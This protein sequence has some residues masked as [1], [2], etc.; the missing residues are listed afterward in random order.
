MSTLAP[1][2]VDLCD[3]QGN[4]LLPYSMKYANHLFVHFDEARGA[5]EWLASLVDGVT[6]ADPDPWRDGQKPGFTLNVAFTAAGLRALG[7][8]DGTMGTFSPEF[9]NGMLASARAL[10]D[11]G[12]SDPA[13][14][15]RGWEPGRVHAMVDV[16]SPSREGVLRQ[17]A[18]VA[19]AMR[20]RGVSDLFSQP[21]A[22]LDDNKEHFGFKDGFG[23]PWLDFAGVPGRRT[24]DHH[25]G[26]G[27]PD[28]KGGWRPVA[29]G[30]F[31]LGHDDEEGIL[32]EAP[33]PQALA[34][35]GTHLVY[36][37]LRQDVEA[38][39][40]YIDSQAQLLGVHAERVAAAMVGRWPDG[41]PLRLSPGKPD[42]DLGKNEDRNNDFT[43][44][45][46]PRGFAC[47]IGA[48]IRRANPR[49]SL[50]FKDRRR[51]ALLVSRHRMIRRGIPYGEPFPKGS[52]DR[53]L[54]FMAAMASLKR[55]FEFVQGQWLN[56]G[57]IFHL[58]ADRDP[59]A[60]DQQCNGKMTIQGC[61][62]KF[63]SGIPPLVVTRGGEYFFKP[64]I[65]AL[66]WLAG[67]GW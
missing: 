60:G 33:Y 32:P 41:S 21:A 35:N 22:R 8:P 2:Q 30:E 65:A 57:N 40:H 9:R 7:V 6:T 47:P 24:P 16:H 38:F 62:P 51:H 56:D 19:S 48:H 13:K 66:R 45:E 34:R 53:G 49:D 14:W 42:P 59:F 29:L 61:P 18:Q 4:I 15:D 50:G 46:D 26:Q 23:Q 39:R 43:Y 10:G 20:G 11:R 67:G 1:P 52:S 12:P 58:G 64:G 31:L 55:Q 3:I 5:R 44:R 36:R 37:K 17:C 54:L 25:N 28:G 27:T 63:I